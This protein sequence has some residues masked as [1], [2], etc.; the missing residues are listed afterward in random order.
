MPIL[1][2]ERT[3]TRDMV[4]GLVD[5]IDCLVRELE[6]AR[7][8]VTDLESE[9]EDLEQKI[10]DLESELRDINEELLNND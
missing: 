10:E 4:F 5:D 8:R 6:E 7:G 1:N 9:V 3:E 2:V